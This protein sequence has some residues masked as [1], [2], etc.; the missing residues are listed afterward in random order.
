VT[1][2]DDAVAEPVETFTVTLGDAVNAVILKSRGTA[3]IEA[4]D[5]ITTSGTPPQSLKPPTTAPALLPKMMLGPSVVQITRGGLAR[6]VLTCV[7]QSPL[8]C[9][10]S[11]TLQT[12]GKPPVKLGVKKFSVRK[13][14]KVTLGI[15]MSLKARRLLAKRPTL[16]ARVV[17]LV[18]TGKTSRRVVPGVITLK[19]APKPAA[20]PKSTARPAP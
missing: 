10:G 12:T 8:T 14:K 11:V 9:T 3:A 19:A 17:V 4:N 20:K 2:I 7:K 18:K 13:G 6:M 16:R 5:R 15:K 1:V